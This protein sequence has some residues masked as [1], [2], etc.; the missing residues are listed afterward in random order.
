MSV[1]LW[2]YN[3]E[4]ITDWAHLSVC[5]SLSLSLIAPMSLEEESKK[6]NPFYVPLLFFPDEGTWCRDSEHFVTAWSTKISLCQDTVIPGEQQVKKA[7]KSSIQESEGWLQSEL[8]I[9]VLSV[10]NIFAFI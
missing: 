6:Y 10:P 9:E 5:L 3:T 2:S 8:S 1:L 7:E 4:F